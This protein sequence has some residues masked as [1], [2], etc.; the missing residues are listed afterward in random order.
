VNERLM[1]ELAE[2][3]RAEQARATLQDEIIRAQD[4]RL[5]E[6]TAPMLPITHQ[7]LVM[8]LIGTMDEARV[9]QVRWAALSGAAARKARY[10]ILDVTGVRTVGEA[11]AEALVRT[12][13]A[14]NLLGVR[15]I[16]TGIRPEMAR[17][18]VDL[19]LDLG[20]LVTHGTLE[21]GFAYAM[22]RARG[23]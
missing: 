1:V 17:A 5:A 22:A 3:R 14:L 4:E 15:V 16:I 23:R 19:G 11:F 7:I 12:A 13:S 2:R 21:S 6:L 18:L 20:T 10:V 8:P 9:E